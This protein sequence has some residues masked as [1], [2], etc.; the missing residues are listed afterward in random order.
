MTEWQTTR[1]KNAVQS[2]LSIPPTV[3]RDRIAR[4][5]VRR[6]RSIGYKAAG[7]GPQLTDSD[8]LPLLQVGI[9]MLTIQLRTG[10]GIYKD[11]QRGDARQWR[12]AATLIRPTEDAYVTSNARQTRLH[13]I[14]PQ[15]FIG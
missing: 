3:A 10:N 6:R 5:E 1:R 15:G 11:G 12:V 7:K 8:S 2:S 13:W 4:E 14:E 9:A